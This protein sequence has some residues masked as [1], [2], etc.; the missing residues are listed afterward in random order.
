MPKVVSFKASTG[1][2]MELKGTWY[3]FSAG[4]EVELEPEDDTNKV[5]EMAWNTVHLEI[6]KQIKEITG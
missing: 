5:K 1:I 4:I 2:S 6:E 3:K